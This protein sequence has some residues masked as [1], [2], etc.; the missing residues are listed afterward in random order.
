MGMKLPMKHSL[1]L[2]VFHWINVPVLV[3]MIWSGLL[4]Y[5]ANQAYIIFPEW[6]VNTFSIHHRLAEGMGWHFFLMWIFAINGIGFIAYTLISGHWKDLVPNSWDLKNLIPFVLSDLHLSKKEIPITDKYNPAQKVFYTSALL[7][8]AMTLVTGLAIYKPVQ[9][10]WLTELLGGYKAARFE[11]F[12]LW[13]GLITFIILHLIQVIR[14]GWQN[15]KTM[16]SG[17]VAIVIILSS[18]ALYYFIKNAD[19]ISGTSPVFHYSFMTNEKVFSLL[20]SAKRMSVQK[21]PVNLGKNPRVNGLIGLKSHASGRDYKIR[22]EQDGKSFEL[23]LATVHLVP[24]KKYTTDFRCIEGWS[25]ETQYAGATFSD[26]MAAQKLGLKPDGKYYQYVGLETPDGEY[27]VSIDMESMLHPQ[28]VLA[29]EM[30]GKTL[31]LNNGFP[32]RLVIPIKYGIKSL[33]RIGKI[34]FSDEKP[35]DYWA[36]RG[37]DWYSGL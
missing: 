15:A 29:W 9:V 19:P 2:R 27:Y 34:I 3:L 20:Q 23:D 24:K 17:L 10:G 31:T 25:E 18:P 6:F 5:W 4:I 12:M 35:R 30:N 22:I 33:K 26:F 7:M 37:Y 36:E 16:A 11:H 28:T 8:A 1:P 14:S 21:K 32:V 13:A